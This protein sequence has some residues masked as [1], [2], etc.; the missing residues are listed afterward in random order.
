MARKRSSFSSVTVSPSQY[1]FRAQTSQLLTPGA[2]EDKNKQTCSYLNSF[3][4]GWY[5]SAVFFG[6]DART[7]VRIFRALARISALFAIYTVAVTGQRRSLRLISDW[8]LIS[9]LISP[10]IIRHAVFLTRITQVAS[11]RWHCQRSLVMR[12]A[13][14]IYLMLISIGDCPIKIPVL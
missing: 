2:L 3:C 5:A 8:Y 4:F 1:F 11:L 14:T 10:C 6:L 7:I 9:Y 13:A 12:M